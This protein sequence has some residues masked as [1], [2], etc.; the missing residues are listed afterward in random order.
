[1]ASFAEA[2]DIPVVPLKAADRLSTA[3]TLVD[4][5]VV[6]DLEAVRGSGSHFED[7]I[8]AEAFA[9]QLQ[10]DESILRG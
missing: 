1:V 3:A 9:Q 4:S 7:A 6:R 8:P 10:L 2:N 5:G